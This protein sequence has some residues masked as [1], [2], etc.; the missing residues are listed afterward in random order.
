MS[1]IP[2]SASSN[3]CIELVQTISI[4]EYTTSYYT[5]YFQFRK[6]IPAPSARLPYRGEIFRKAPI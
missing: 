6:I 1:I 2:N 3:K 5:C 4:Y